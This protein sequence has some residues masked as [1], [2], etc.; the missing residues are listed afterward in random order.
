MGGEVP[1]DG[2][3]LQTRSGIWFETTG[4]FLEEAMQRGAKLRP[5]W[6]TPPK[7]DEVKR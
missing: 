2:Y 1:P 3:M 7:Q 6:L 5:F 4:R